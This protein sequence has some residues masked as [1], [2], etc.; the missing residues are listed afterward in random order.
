MKTAFH[1]Y[2]FV[3]TDGLCGNCRRE[4]IC[5]TLGSV[6]KSKKYNCLNDSPFFSSG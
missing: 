2:G 6:L 5:A 3:Y 4:Q 1:F